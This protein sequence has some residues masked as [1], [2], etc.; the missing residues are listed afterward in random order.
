VPYNDRHLLI[1]TFVQF[2][3]LDYGTENC[4]FAL[5][6]PEHGSD[7]MEIARI[8]ATIDIWA[9]AVDSEVDLPKLSYETLPR[10][11][12]KLGVF[13]PRYNTM[14]RLPSFAC[15]SG[16]Y[17]AFLLTALKEDCWSM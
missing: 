11:V 10:R 16:T 15:E 13:T 4:S 12:S 5:H 2:R 8:G 14:K 6:I 1:S 9:V 17:C 7:A 3:V